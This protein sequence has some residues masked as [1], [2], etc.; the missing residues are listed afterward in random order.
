MI[1]LFKKQNLKSISPLGRFTR[2]RVMGLRL[3]FVRAA[4][5]VLLIASSSTTFAQGS[6][7]WDG[8]DNDNWR[9]DQNWTGGSSPTINQIAI[10]ERNISRNNVDLANSSGNDRDREVFTLRLRTNGNGTVIDDYFGPNQD[11]SANW[12][13]RRG[14]I[15]IPDNPSFSNTQHFSWVDTRSTA[16]ELT[17]LMD[18]DIPSGNV[19]FSAEGEDGWGGSA[20]STNSIETLNFY[21]NLSGTGTINLRSNFFGS[22]SSYRSRLVLHEENEFQGTLI[23]E[24]DAELY[25]RDGS[26]LNMAELR[27][28]TGSIFNIVSLNLVAFEAFINNSTVNIAS[29]QALGFASRAD[30]IHG[31][32]Y[33]G[34]GTIVYFGTDQM[35]LRGTNSFSGR[36]AASGPVHLEFADVLANAE[37]DADADNTLSFAQDGTVLGGLSGP[38]DLIIDQ[39]LVLDSNAIN[40]EYSGDLTGNGSIRQFNQTNWT[41]SGISSIPFNI[42]SGTLSGNGTM[43]DVTVDINGSITPG[44]SEA[45]GEIGTQQY[46]SLHLDGEMIIDLNGTNRDQVQVSGTLDLSGAQLTVRESNFP[47]TAVII[48]SYGTLNGTFDTVSGLPSGVDVKYLWNNGS[49]NVKNIALVPNITPSAN[50]DSY[51]ISQDGSLSSE[52][53]LANDSDGDL[54]AI[55]VASPLGEFSANGIG[56]TVNLSADGSFTYAPPNAAVGNA[57]FSYTVEDNN[58]AQD[59]ATVTI[60]VQNILPQAANDDFTIDEDGVLTGVN[61]LINDQDSTFDTLMVANP[62]TITPNGIGGT[63]TLSAT[64]ELNYTP[65]ADAFGMAT[66]DYMIEDSAGATD[67]AT[68]QIEIE[69]VNDAPTFVASNPPT[70]NEDG[71][72]QAVF[73]WAIFDAGATNESTQSFLEY[74]VTNISNPSLFLVAPSIDQF[75][76]LN[77]TPAPEISGTSTF[78][79]SVQDDGGTANGGVDT[80]TTQTFTITVNNLNDAPSFSAS[81]PAAIDE[82]SGAQILNDWATFDPGATNENSQSVLGYSVSNISNA[83][84][85]AAAPMIDV[86]GNLSYT[87]APDANGTSTFDVSV[88]DDGGTANGGVDISTTQTFTITVN[89]INDAPSFT[90]TD[91]SAVNEN[92][93]AQ[94]VANWASFDPGASN[95]SDQGALNYTV[96]NVSAPA[97][98][99]AGPTVDQAG[100]LTY[101][102]ADDANGMATFDVAV[103]DDGGTANGG[104][105]TSAI[106]TFTITVNAVNNAPTITATDPT[107]IN[108]DAGPQTLTPWASFDPGASNESGQSALNYTVSNISTPALFTSVPA[109]DLQGNLTYTPTDNTSG[110]A[111]FDVTVQDDGGTANGGQDTS[112]VQTFTITVNA[113]NDAPTFTATDP[114]TIN[115]D[116]GL[117]TLTGWASFDPGAPN[118]SDQNVLNYTVANVSTPALFA[119]GPTVDLQGNLTY[120]PANNASGTA[121]FDVS[122]QDDGGTA[123]GGQ[124]TS[125]VQTFTITINAVN[126]APTFT[127]TDPDA[128]NE[129]AGAQTLSAWAS[130]DPGASNESGQSVLNY[131]VTK[132]SEPAL[133]ASAPA[134]DQQG[135]LTY[136]PADDAN[137]TA[138]FDLTVQDDGGTDNGGIDTSATQTFTITIN[139]V[140]DAPF[141]TAAGLMSVTLGS[142][143]QEIQNWATFDPGPANES[144]QTVQDYIVGNDSNPDL[145]DAL[146]MVD[147]NGVLRFTP[148]PQLTGSSTFDVQVV[149]NGGTA[150]NG[151]NTSNVQTFTI[152]VFEPVIFSNGFESPIVNTSFKVRAADLNKADIEART[153]GNEEPVLILRASDAVNADY[154]EV[155]ASEVNGTI[156]IQLIGFEGGILVE[157]DWQ[158]LEEEGSLLTI[159]W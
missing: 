53:V 122:V 80:S 69:P 86:S 39:T 130:F 138:T 92:A 49:G 117:Q 56:G 43:A 112:V 89:A 18:L 19:V 113:V 147:Q 114:V 42:E 70:I 13:F 97:L 78:D 65:T 41:Y 5:I 36:L 6:R 26:A 115:E 31:G 98:F 75:G 154:L 151:E 81:D 46:D 47:S 96:S 54:D 105:E 95:E 128:I 25:L 156:H 90:A 14:R 121:T 140:N 152:T 143:A 149:D 74:T 134:V 40:V 52:N 30:E 106:Q 34:S 87:P 146:P 23:V 68:I 148:K 104:Q 85:F 59:T 109:V 66:F 64:G 110:T 88:Q 133:F 33:T 61:V 9:D 10:M 82:D 37:F 60:Q 127:A 125:D 145:F 135:N 91:P 116:A 155:Y 73:D 111:T 11:L 150:N 141:F 63:A 142:G 101:T 129:D 131:T 103:Q 44:G 38:G 126:N 62:G 72:A 157:S 71:G 28:E 7:F 120:T 12:R 119:S 123:N 29:G 57:T 137:G 24:D 32:T 50:N 45:S 4:A 132:V 77:Y 136:T 76:D 3:M 144:S 139:A 48:T 35:T 1:T 124:D 2:P 21:G 67:T 153:R 58:G 8:S 107:A 83:A 159:Q 16:D 118:E 55:T 79:V 17:V 94:T 102:P 93:G 99:A 27:L 20:G 51:S 158:A 84:L 15:Q 100:N 22:S 108:E